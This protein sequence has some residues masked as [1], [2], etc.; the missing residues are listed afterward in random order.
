MG[1]NPLIVGRGEGSQE[2]KTG[3]L[4]L[5]LTLLSGIAG[6]AEIEQTGALS[7]SREAA[8]AA[9]KETTPTVIQSS[10]SNRLVSSRQEGTR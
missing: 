9:R 1:H 3:R 4:P 5:K 8:E 6:Q 2:P 7:A 10:R